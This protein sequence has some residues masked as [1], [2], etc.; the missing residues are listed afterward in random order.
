M[1]ALTGQT[2]MKHWLP[3]IFKK[4]CQ[5]IYSTN[6]KNYMSKVLCS[7][8]SF[9]DNTASCNRKFS[10]ISVLFQLHKLCIYI[11][12]TLSGNPQHTMKTA[13]ITA[14]SIHPLSMFVNAENKDVAVS[15]FRVPATGANA[16]RKM[17][18][19]RNGSLETTMLASS[20]SYAV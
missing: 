18:R 15:R 8:L 4:P 16:T 3:G 6:M 20:L 5:N 2:H 1:C 13:L 9:N 10:Q 17:A 14:S 19:G 11:I 7:F 12:S